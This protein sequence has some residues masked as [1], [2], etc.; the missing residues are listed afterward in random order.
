[1]HDYDAGIAF[2]DDIIKYHMNHKDPN[3]RSAHKKDVAEYTRVKQAWELDKQTG[4]HG[5]LQDVI[6]TSDVISW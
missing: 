6:R 3:H 4:K 1:M 2:M 5:H